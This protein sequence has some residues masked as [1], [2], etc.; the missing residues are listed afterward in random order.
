MDSSGAFRAELVGPLERGRDGQWHPIKLLIQVLRARGDVVTPIAGV[1]DDYGEDALLS[2]NSA[3]RTV[4]VVTLPVR[5]AIWK[6][7]ASSGKAFVRGSAQE[8]VELVRDALVHKK[9]QPAGT[10]LVLDASQ[11]GAIVRPTLVEMYISKYGEPEIEFGVSGA[12]I[13]GPTLRS[14]LRLK[15]A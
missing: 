1:R 12:W 14:T 7:L 8:A 4:Q 9:G 10:I 3:R 11:L 15:S 5:G 2:V 6:E 13:V